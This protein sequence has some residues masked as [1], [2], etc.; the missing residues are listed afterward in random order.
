MAVVSIQCDRLVDMGDDKEFTATAKVWVTN[1]A[2]DLAPAAA[3]VG[4]DLFG[5]YARSLPFTLI[6]ERRLL[7]SEVY[8]GLGSGGIELMPVKEVTVPPGYLP[9]SLDNRKASRS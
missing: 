6:G 9:V 2:F 5:A 1:E 3:H 4:T 7:D 8:Q